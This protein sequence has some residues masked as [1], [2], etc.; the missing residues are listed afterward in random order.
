MGLGIRKLP[1]GLNKHPLLLG[2]AMDHGAREL[3][4]HSKNQ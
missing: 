1:R 3:E 4:G 2:E